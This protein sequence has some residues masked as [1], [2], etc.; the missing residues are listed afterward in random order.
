MFVNYSFFTCLLQTA[1]CLRRFP[2]FQIFQN[3]FGVE[4]YECALAEKK[5]YEMGEFDKK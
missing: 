4:T 1:K 2:F 5:W 3:I